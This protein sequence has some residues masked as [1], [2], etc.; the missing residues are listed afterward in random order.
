MRYQRTQ[1]Q[2]ISLTLSQKINYF[3]F[4]SG[5]VTLIII[6]KLFSLQVIA[7]DH[8]QGIATR[9]QAGYAELPAQRGEILIKD[10]HSQ[11]EFRLATNTTLYLIYADPLLIEDNIMV[12]ETL[13]PLLFNLELEREKDDIR[14]AD[15]KKNMP[16]DLTEEATAEYLEKITPLSDFDLEVNHKKNLIE[17]LGQKQ[18]QQILLSNKLD[19]G[20]LQNIQRLGLSGIEVSGNSVLAYPPQVLDRS[21]TAKIL[22]EYVEIPSQRLETI[23]EGK[24]RYIVLRNKLEADIANQI[25]DIIKTDDTFRGIGMQEEYYRFYPEQSLAANIVGYISRSNIGQYG[26]EN[27]FDSILKG[28]AGQFQ[29][30]QDVL[31]R[32]ITVGDS[33]LE[34]AVDGADV[35][36]TIDRS[37]QMMSDQII[38]QAVKEFAAESG[39]ILI[40]DPKTGAII[41]MSHYPTFNPNSYGDAFNRVKVEYSEQDMENLVQSTDDPNTYYFYTN[42]LTK[43]RYTVFKEYDNNGSA[44]YYRYENFVGPEVYHNKIV[45]WPYEPGSVFKTVTMAIAIDSGDVTPSTT[46]NDDGPVGVDFNVYSG[47]YDFEIKN[48]T[49]YYGLVNMSTVLAK[50]LNTG[51]TFVAKKIGPALFYNYMK[52]FGLLEKTAIEFNGETTG[53]IRHYD[54]W[55][56]SELATASFGQGITATMLQVANAYSAIV[57][58]GILMKPYII[59]EIRYDDGNIIKTE[60]REIRRVISEETSDK[61]IAMLKYTVEEGLTPASKINGHHVGGKSGTSQTYRNGKALTGAGTTIG[62]FAGFGP[63]DDP[64]FLILVKIDKSRTSE[65]GSSTAAVAF[66]RMATYLFNYYNIPPDKD[67]VSTSLTNL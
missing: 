3:V 24:N 59:E 47:E 34:P 28:K 67:V 66:N 45:S 19:Q 33:I 12:G 51:M 11:E 46:Y 8:Y 14:I 54:Q 60:P 36:L 49:T 21:S 7:H 52:K 43:D 4:F 2:T 50:S 40:M 23:L 57:N 64:Q 44:H 18:R 25:K 9:L 5:I 29:T 38:E 20:T 6:F 42:P 37:V 55:T 63:V 13:S 1:R 22:S 16:L 61:M 10:H 56:E 31:G 53:Q 58:G 15:L 48:A 30:K 41:A 39:Q 26:I 27:S 65:W 35:V 17:S 32:Q 62:T